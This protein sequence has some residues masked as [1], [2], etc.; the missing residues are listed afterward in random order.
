MD[1]NFEWD[2]NKARTN[3]RVHRVSFEEAKTVFDDPLSITIPDPL[4]SAGEYRYTDIG[5][6]STG[7]VLVVVYIERGSNIRIISSRDAIKSERRK[8]EEGNF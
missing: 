3:L 8:H 2:E 4:H 1:S 6:S 7:R 5:R